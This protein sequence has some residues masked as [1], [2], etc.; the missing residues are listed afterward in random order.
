MLNEIL[1]QFN[2]P[3]TY[4]KATVANYPNFVQDVISA[5]KSNELSEEAVD[6]LAPFFRVVGLPTRDQVS[7]IGEFHLTDNIEH[8][9]SFLACVF[10][11]ETGKVFFDTLTD[12]ERID[13]SS[14]WVR[15]M[16]RLA[17]TELFPRHALAALWTSTQPRLRSRM[18]YKMEEERKRVNADSQIVYEVCNQLAE[19]S[20]PF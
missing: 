3:A 20:L 15:P 12:E 4:L 16:M 10:H 5:I 6:S 9:Q 17:M 11:T 2:K 14:P 7:F 19:F 8:K 13:Y 18:V 1:P